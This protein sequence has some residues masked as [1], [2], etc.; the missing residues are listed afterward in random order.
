MKVNSEKKLRV[1]REKREGENGIN[2]R[3]LGVGE[4]T[5]NKRVRKE[6]KER[7]RERRD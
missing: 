1:G 2:E 5:G 6:R 3:E 7:K 4:R